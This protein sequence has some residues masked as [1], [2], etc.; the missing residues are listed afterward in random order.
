[1]WLLSGKGSA[2]QCRR[3]RTCRFDPWIRKIPWRRA[4]Q[5]TPVFLPGKY[6][7]QRRLVG[8]SPWGHRESDTTEWLSIHVNDFNLLSSKRTPA[9]EHPPVNKP[10]FWIQYLK[11]IWTPY[12]RPEG[13]EDPD[14]QKAPLKVN[15]ERGW[16]GLMRS[17]WPERNCELNRV[18]K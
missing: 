6:D 16:P 3:P 1:M 9:L 2:C 13:K 8:C 10:S 5:P 7:G 15:V 14:W 4:W 18:Y 11:I 17:L 12:T